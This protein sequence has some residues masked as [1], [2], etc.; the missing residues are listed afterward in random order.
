VAS[1]RLKTA[2]HETFSLSRPALTQI[3]KV[4]GTSELREKPTT[5]ESRRTLLRQGTTL[6]TNYVKAMPRYG[7]GAGLLC[8]GLQLTAFGAIAHLRDPLLES[9][10]TQWLMHYHLSAPYGPGPAFWHH[11]VVTRF[12]PGEEF[13]S[14]DIEQDI[15]AF[16][17]RTEGKKLSRNSTRPTATAFLGTYVKTDGLGKLGILEQAVARRYRVADVDPPPVWAFAAAL[18]DYWLGN[19]R[20]YLTVN[21]EQISGDGKLGSIFLLNPGRVNMLLS[22]MQREGYVEL[23][24]LA[25]PHQLVLLQSDEE[26]MLRRMYDIG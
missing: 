15:A 11:L 4:A 2:F 10:S 6:G 13:D 1:Q 16:V 21:L 7:W 18:V 26:L 3:M 9:A 23:H 19:F 17:E 8:S 25:P 24:R 14:D 5:S 12:L 20:D 22:E